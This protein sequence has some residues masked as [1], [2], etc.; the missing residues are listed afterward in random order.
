MLQITNLH[1]GYEQLQILFGVNCEAKFN[2]ITLLIGPNGAGKSTV[3]KS[4]FNLV[5]IYD[6]QIRVDRREITKIPTYECIQHGLAYVPQGRPIFPNLNV[7]EN[8]ELGGLLLGR[9]LLHER[10]EYVFHEFPVLA[11]KAKKPARSLSGGQ[12]QMVVLARALMPSPKLLL[13][14]E[15]SLGLSPVMMQGIFEKLVELKKQGIGTLLV[16]QNAKAASAIADK[17]YLLENGQVVLSGGREIL[18]HEKI[19]RV[20]LGGV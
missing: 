19:K 4:I 12:Q 10:V 15:P 11:L 16:E 2:E 8:I 6:G 14:D 17:I 7:R 18:A 13:L 5:D 1:A 3:L 9:S 20:H